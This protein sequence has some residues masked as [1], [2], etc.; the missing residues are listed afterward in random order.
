MDLGLEGKISRGPKCG[1]NHL[2]LDEMN[3]LLFWAQ[4]G[5]ARELTEGH[6]WA[7]V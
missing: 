4:E 2:M 6:T 7:S 1:V 5:G 3:N